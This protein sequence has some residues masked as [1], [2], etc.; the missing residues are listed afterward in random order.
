MQLAQGERN[1]NNILQIKHTNNSVN[2]EF[3]ILKEKWFEYI[4]QEILKVRGCFPLYT[5]Q[6]TLYTYVCYTC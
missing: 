6:T 4:C 5:H 1:L 2:T 3:K